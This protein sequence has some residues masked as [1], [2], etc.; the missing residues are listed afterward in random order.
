MGTVSATFE[1]ECTSVNAGLAF[2][3]VYGM[4]DKDDLFFTISLLLISLVFFLILRY[5]HDIHWFQDRTAL[6][7][8]EP[9]R[10]RH[11]TCTERLLNARRIIQVAALARVIFILFMSISKSWQLNNPYGRNRLAPFTQGL[12]IQAHPGTLCYLEIILSLISQIPITN[13]CLI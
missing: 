13:L 4:N 11:R 6:R 10:C 7:R 5:D 12:I 8:K 1:P 3:Y 2:R 9:L